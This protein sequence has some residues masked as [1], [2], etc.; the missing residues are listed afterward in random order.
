MQL[1]EHT[2]PGEGFGASLISQCEGGFVVV[3]AGVFV[4]ARWDERD[5]VARAMFLVAGHLNGLKGKTLARLAFV[6]PSF[7]TRTL[8]RY[9]RGGAAAL[10]QRE[11]SGPTPKL[12]AD[13]RKRARALRRQGES[14]RT[15]AARLG[16]GLATLAVELKGV[17]A[18]P[19][20]PPVHPGLPHVD[21]SAP[22]VVHDEQTTPPQEPVQTPPQVSA[23]SDPTSSPLPPST[24]SCASPDEDDALSAATP[25]RCW[26]WARCEAW[27]WTT[28][29]RAPRSRARGRRST[30]PGRRW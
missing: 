1:V 11:R 18:G 19:A 29:W 28:R 9:E 6:P 22:A 13:A 24:P 16:V 14:L 4:L 27:A 3:M 26:R 5:T 17:P 25:G 8:Q 2:L 23:G 30:R 10:W 21:S 20:A 12:D 15:I 7:V